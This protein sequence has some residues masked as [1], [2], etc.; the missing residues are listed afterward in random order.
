MNYD[1]QLKKEKKKKQKGKDYF[2]SFMVAKDLHG[3]YHFLQT[4]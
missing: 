1:H 4:Q 2:Y 3:F